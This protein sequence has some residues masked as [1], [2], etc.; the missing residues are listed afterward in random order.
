MNKYNRG[1]SISSIIAVIAGFFGASYT[2]TKTPT[3]VVNIS[4]PNPVVYV[5]TTT[6]EIV[7]NK[8]DDSKAISF[9]QKVLTTLESNDFISL[10]SMVSPDGLNLNMYPYIY[11]SKN[12]IP[13]NEIANINND[14]RTYIWG[15]TDGKG[16]PVD[17]SRADFIKRLLASPVSFSKAKQ[18]SVNKKLGGGNTKFTLDK[19][20]K[21]MTYVAFH[22]RTF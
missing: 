7:L 5:A 6:D 3:P 13:K 19:D 16:D 2:F 20:A 15:Y 21:G 11:W 9:S 10:S 18:I 17:L 4:N 22:F 1:F 8:K 14:A 12:N